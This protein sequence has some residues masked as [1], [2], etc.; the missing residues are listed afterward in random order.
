MGLFR[1]TAVNGAEGCASG[2]SSSFRGWCALRLHDKATEAMCAH[3]VPT[4]FAFLRRGFHN[5]RINGA[6]A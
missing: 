2:L 5:V 4:G 6:R 1:I 3:V